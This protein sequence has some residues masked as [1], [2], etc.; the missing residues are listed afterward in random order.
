MLLLGR[1]GTGPL[2]RRDR[3]PAPTRPSA[4]PGPGPAYG[5]LDGVRPG[6]CAQRRTRRSPTRAICA[7][8]RTELV[9]PAATQGPEP[10]LL[11]SLA[12]VPAAWPPRGEAGEASSSRGPGR[13]VPKPSPLSSSGLG[14]TPNP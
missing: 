11:G 9:E 12:V 2:G 8:G 13:W 10:G 1:G 4:L 7:D 5:L 3:G 14:P 6:H